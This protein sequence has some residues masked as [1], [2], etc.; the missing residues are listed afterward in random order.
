MESS[1]VGVILPLLIFLCF[2]NVCADALAQRLI[3]H[4]DSDLAGVGVDTVRAMFTMRLR[5][6][7]DGRPVRVFV[8]PDV[9]PT[10]REFAKKVVGVLPYQLRR[11]WDRGVFTGTSQAPIEVPNE[12]EMLDR[13]STT[14]GAVGYVPDRTG[15]KRVRFLPVE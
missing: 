13:V 12:S 4:P 2:G 8:L 14:P 10:H 15:D 6:W 11:A 3:V 9:D 7:P 5:R 1:R